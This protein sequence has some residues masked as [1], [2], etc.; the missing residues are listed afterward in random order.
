M[1]SNRAHTYGK[2]KLDFSSEKRTDP[3]IQS[4]DF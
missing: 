3:A 2:K 4:Q 1:E